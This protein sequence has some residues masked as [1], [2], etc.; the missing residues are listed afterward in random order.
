MTA[1]HGFPN[2]G[3]V[4]NPYDEGAIGAIKEAFPTAGIA[5]AEVADGVAADNR[6]HFVVAPP[7][8]M[9]RM[10]ECKYRNCA[11]ADSWVSGPVGFLISGRYFVA[12]GECWALQL[13]S[14]YLIYQT[15]V[16]PDGICGS[17]IVQE[18]FN[19][20]PSW[21]S[22]LLGQYRF[23]ANDGLSVIHCLDPLTETC[24]DM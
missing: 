8:R 12:G 4:F 24:W 9:A 6:D 20:N 2:E 19:G 21:V 13:Q 10:A 18:D 17:S 3:T 16:L 5:L 15:N 7:Q 11:R 22:S 14:R 23:A 1:L